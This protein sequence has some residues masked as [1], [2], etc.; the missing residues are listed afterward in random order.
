MLLYL[1]PM[2]DPGRKAVARK[3]ALFV[4]GYTEH[5]ALASFFHRWL[6]PKLPKGNRVGIVS[7]RFNGIGDF[8]QKVALKVEFYLSENK[9]NF[10]FGLADLYG[11]PQDT[12][13]FSDC[14]NVDE[15]VKKG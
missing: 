13:D 1:L 9:S 12:I 15:K 6:D 2:D 10:I 11:L 7:V 4:E 3:I 14:N 5:Q 8:I